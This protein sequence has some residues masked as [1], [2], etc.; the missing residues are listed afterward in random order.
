MILSIDFDSETPIYTQ[1]S[2][3]IIKGIACQELTE[4]EKLPTVRQLASDIGVNLHTINKAYNN[5]KIRGF[6]SI[7]RRKGVV[8][9]SK[10]SFLY[11][12]DYL[13]ELK[14]N[15]APLIYEAISRDVDSKLVINLVN[16]LYQTVEEGK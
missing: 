12:T 8:I 10:D 9:N 7:N 13:D 1:I 6:L 3:Q 2:N 14:D 11:D 16:E 4:G 5:L 15:L